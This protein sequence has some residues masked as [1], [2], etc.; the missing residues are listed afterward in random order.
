MVN[1]NLFFRSLS[2]FFSLV[3]LVSVSAIHVILFGVYKYLASAYK[4]MDKGGP[5]SFLIGVSIP[6]V[7]TRYLF[8]YFSRHTNGIRK[9]T[10][11]KNQMPLHVTQK[12]E[13]VLKGS[14]PKC[15]ELIL[16]SPSVAELV[17][18]LQSPQP[19][20]QDGENKKKNRK[21][22]YYKV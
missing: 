9:K 16:P 8:I 22:V 7:F 4:Q 3:V 12:R 5:Y 1:F 2:F 6:P 20:E 11:L 14:F 10:R 17:P 13:R 15:V 21:T 18:A 19:K